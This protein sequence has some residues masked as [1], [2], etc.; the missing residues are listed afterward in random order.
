MTL[1]K[2]P[3][4]HKKDHATI[5]IPLS[6]DLPAGV[7]YLIPKVNLKPPRPKTISKENWNTQRVM[8]S[9]LKMVFC[10]HK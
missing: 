6:S 4:T 1:I 3:E 8:V 7:L 5:E 2:K 10:C 9:C